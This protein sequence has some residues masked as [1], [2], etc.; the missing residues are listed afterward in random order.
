MDLATAQTQYAAALAAYNAALAARATSMEDRSLQN[1]DIDKL[2][3][4]VEYWD[5]KVLSLT[6]TAAGRTGG[7]SIARWQS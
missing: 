7:Y 3:G 2:R 6:D 4:E 1:H 5:R